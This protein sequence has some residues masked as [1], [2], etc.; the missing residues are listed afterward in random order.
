MGEGKQ[1]PDPL[2]SDDVAA[3]ERARLRILAGRSATTEVLN[4]LAGLLA[5]TERCFALTESGEQQKVAAMDAARA[6]ISKAL[7]GSH[8]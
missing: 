3:C 2:L 8:G 1:T 7:G 5:V 4:A 6:A